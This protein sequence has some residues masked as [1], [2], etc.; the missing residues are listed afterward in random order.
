MRRRNMDR[1]E[2]CN[3]SRIAND[4]EY[5]T[6]EQVA[7]EMR[8]FMIE[9]KVKQTVIDGFQEVFRKQ[10]TLPEIALKND[11]GITPVI[12]KLYARKPNK[13]F[14]SFSQKMSMIY[15]ILIF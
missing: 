14:L 5:L 4:L 11:L 12:M 13:V 8:L 2:L 15:K 9:K 1:C 6:P 3:C 10:G 7:E